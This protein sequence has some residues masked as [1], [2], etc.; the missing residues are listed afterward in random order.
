[1]SAALDVLRRHQEQPRRSSVYIGGR[2]QQQRRLRIN[3]RRCSDCGG[4]TTSLTRYF[5]AA[6]HFAGW[7]WP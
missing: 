5:C 6:C 7:W 3:T 1:M 2:W 4:P